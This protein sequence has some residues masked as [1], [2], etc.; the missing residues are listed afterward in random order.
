TPHIGQRNDGQ[1]WPDKGQYA[2]SDGGKTTQQDQPPIVSQWSEQCRNAIQAI[3]R[4]FALC[5][6]HED[7]QISPRKEQSGLRRT[8]FDQRAYSKGG[9]S[10]RASLVAPGRT[11]LSS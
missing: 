10:F 3:C 8:A 5:I 11:S 7:L 4:S 6:G 1:P 2:E 9:A